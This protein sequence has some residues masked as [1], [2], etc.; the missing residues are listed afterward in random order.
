MDGWINIGLGKG[1]ISGW[2]QQVI[3]QSKGKES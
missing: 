2:S 1:G 3:G